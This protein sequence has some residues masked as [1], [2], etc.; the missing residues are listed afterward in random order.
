MKKQLL[1]LSCL[2]VW[3]LT[4]NASEN[5]LTKST[6]KVY[7]PEEGWHITSLSE[8]NYEENGDLLS[9]QFYVQSDMSDSI[10]LEKEFVNIFNENGVLTESKEYH[11]RPEKTL[12]SVAVFEY[13]EDGTDKKRTTTKYLDSGVEYIS[14]HYEVIKEDITKWIQQEYTYDVDLQRVK[15]IR[16][17]TSYHN[18]YDHRIY[19]SHYNRLADSD[20]LQLWVETYNEYEYVENS[21]SV[22]TSYHHGYMW[23]NKLRRRYLADSTVYSYTDEMRVETFYL[24]DTVNLKYDL[25]SKTQWYYDEDRNEILY[26]KY[27]V[28]DETE[29]LIL[30]SKSNTIYDESGRKSSIVDSSYNFK[31]N[32]LEHR[33]TETYTYNGDEYEFS[34][35][36]LSKV[37][38]SKNEY[39]DYT[40]S[41]TYNYSHS[42]REQILTFKLDAEYLDDGSLVSS[43]EHKFWRED[44]GDWGRI[45]LIENEY[46]TIET[47][48]DDTEDL[49]NQ[50]IHPNPATSTVQLPAQVTKLII[51]DILGR[52]YDLINENG[53]VDVSSLQ[54]GTYLFSYTLDKK[55]VT[56]LVVVQ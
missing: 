14:Y 13:Y 12:S 19:Y 2:L 4:S 8:Y 40:K 36:T 42:A 50:C 3:I 52:S 28:I 55:Q 33:K 43:L 56:E 32:V 25:A 49:Y 34:S 27:R 26:E 29:T 41:Y 20:T 10:M 17:D 39:G 21:S 5:L 11:F 47:S 23:D 7:T 46:V 44:E 15:L 6:T 53:T 31:I 1:V 24:Y 16:L 45:Q 37:I 54:K 18:E 38:Q 30:T 35:D 48:I 51:T 9:Y 22:T